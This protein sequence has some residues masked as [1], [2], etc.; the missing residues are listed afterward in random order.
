[1]KNKTAVTKIVEALNKLKGFECGY[2]TETFDDGYFVV[3]IDGE[4]FA[5]KLERFVNQERS[6]S[7]AIDQV[8]YNI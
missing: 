5:V 3:E 2:S 8:K 6:L 4:K 7:E 1:M